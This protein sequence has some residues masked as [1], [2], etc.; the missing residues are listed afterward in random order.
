MSYMFS[1][2]NSLTNLYLSNFNIKNVTNMY[3]VFSVCE[4]LTNKFI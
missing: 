4:S 1:G 2:C 3:G